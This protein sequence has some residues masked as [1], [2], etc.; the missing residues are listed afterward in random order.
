MIKDNDL[1]ETKR[2]LIAQLILSIIYF[3][4]GMY[5]LIVNIINKN[6]GLNQELNIVLSLIGV[7]GG[8]AVYCFTI[9][10]NP[11]KV[12]NKTIKAYDPSNKDIKEKSI[13]NAYYFYL[14]LSIILI[15][16]SY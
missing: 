2:I 7:G 12:R 6:I 4:S 11:K 5:M 14:I 16:V 1:K 9:L 3:L 13:R 10:V 8:C 15:I